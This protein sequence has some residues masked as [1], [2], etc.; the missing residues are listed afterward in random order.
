M[1]KGLK[2]LYIVSFSLLAIAIGLIVMLKV[3]KYNPF[4]KNKVVNIIKIDY[5]IDDPK[6]SKEITSDTKDDVDNSSNNKSDDSSSSSDSAQNNKNNS[7]SNSNN[8]NSSKNN[9][10]SNKPNNNN[11]SNSQAPSCVGKPTMS[12]EKVDFKT[13]SACT[14]YISAYNVNNTT[15]PKSCWEVIDCK[16][17]TLGYMLLGD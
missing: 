7:S 8:N 17:T 11:S 3:F 6:E 10:S 13:L 12:W 1:T 9:N 15:D 2:I 14:N 5:I 4:A 16:G